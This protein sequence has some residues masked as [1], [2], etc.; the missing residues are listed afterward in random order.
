M[1][2]IPKNVIKKTSATELIAA[3]AGFKVA[4]RTV[5]NVRTAS[6]SAK[7]ALM[8]NIHDVLRMIVISQISNVASTIITFKEV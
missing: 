3:I 6:N 8:M 4:F 7:G 5:C 1:V 2:N